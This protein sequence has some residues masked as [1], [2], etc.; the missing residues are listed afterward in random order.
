M[1][2]RNGKTARMDIPDVPVIDPLPVDLEAAGSHAATEVPVAGPAERVG[3]VRRRLIGHEFESIADVAVC[4]PDRRFIGLAAIERVMAADEDVLLGSIMDVDPPVIGRHIDQ[5]RAAWAVL[6]RNGTSTA[7]VD[8]QGRFVGL[9]P[10]STLLAILLNEH[11]EDILRLSGLLS[12]S[13]GARTSVEERVGRR[14]LH[15]LPWLAIGLLGAMLS[16]WVVSSAEGQLVEMVQLAFF[17]PAIVYMAD[18]V[19]TQTETLAVR[20]L[21][22]GIAIRRFVVKELAAGALIGALIAAAFFP[23]C[24]AVFGDAE[25]ALVVSLALLCSCGVATVVALTL[26]WVIDRFGADPAFG[27]GPLS[28]VIQDLLSIV[29]YLALAST[30]LP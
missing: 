24:L 30:L 8:E 29:I 12:N 28:T 16:A 27:A 20:G 21:S 19:G 17:L 15:R 10:P 26:P 23:F 6:E 7:V 4:S 2:W 14:L 22:V 25:L 9:I 13:R 18:A 1:P 11:E 5:E 3:D